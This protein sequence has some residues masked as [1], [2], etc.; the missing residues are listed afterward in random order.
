MLRRTLLVVTG[1]VG[2]AGVL[3][4]CLPAE[5]GGGDFSQVSYCQM[6]E[7][8]GGHCGGTAL[9]VNAHHSI[10]PRAIVLFGN[11]EQKRQYLPKLASGE[12][13]SAFALTEL[14]AFVAAVAGAAPAGAGLDEDRRAVAVGVAAR[15]SAVAGRPLA[16]G[17]DWPWP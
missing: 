15:A 5:F 3:G 4:A 17:T 11:E 7:V 14:E 13:I 12:W 10:G 8:L 9:F 2:I 6:I 16:V 1:V